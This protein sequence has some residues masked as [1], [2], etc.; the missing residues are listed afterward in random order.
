MLFVCLGNICRSPMAEAIALHLKPDGHFDSA[1]TAGYHAG[2]RADPRTLAVLDEHG[3]RYDGRSRKVHDQDFERFPLILAMDQRNL[4]AL[5][6]RCPP[7]H[8]HKLHLV[9]EPLGVGREVGDPYYGGPDGFN[10]VY[11]ELTEA[12]EHWLSD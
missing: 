9:L 8:R 1:G 4:K 5:R 2:E 3:I 7:E 6:R 10:L 11:A 12:L